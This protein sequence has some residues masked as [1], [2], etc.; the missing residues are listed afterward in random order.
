MKAIYCV[1]VHNL[2]NF[3]T[4]D[5]KSVE[6]CLLD[7]EASAVSEAFKTG[8]VITMGKVIAEPIYK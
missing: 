6:L 1:R 2:D 3:D 4:Y 5:V 7:C 8:D